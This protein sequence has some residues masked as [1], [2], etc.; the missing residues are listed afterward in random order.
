MRRVNETNIDLN[1]NFDV[2]KK[3]FSLKN[4][5]YPILMGLLNPAEKLG[6]RSPGYLFFPARAVYYIVK[7]G[8]GT[9]RQSILQG[10]YEFEKGIYYGGRDFSPQKAAIEKLIARSA[11]GATQVFVMDLH[12]G[13]GERNRL[14][15][16][17][18]PITDKRNRAAAERVFEGYQVDWGGS[19]DFY[20]TTGD[21]T[22]YIEKLFPEKTVIRMTS[23]Y[24]TMDSQ[25]TLGSID[26]LKVTIME[27]QAF[28]YGGRS[29]SDVAKAKERFREMYYPSSEL[30][31]FEILRQ[32]AEQ[33]PVIFSRFSALK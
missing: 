15:Y 18:N 20:I 17:P 1:R 4:E 32:T 11:K 3:L 28:H 24:G 14:H 33:F 29:K 26:S 30:W 5:G 10:Q 8:M 27:N 22:D 6:V 23:E 13:Y 25:T 7:F 12:T 2:D 21:F 16:F 31:R 9:L 19:G